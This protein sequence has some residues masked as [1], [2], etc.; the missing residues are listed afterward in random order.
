MGYPA[1]MFLAFGRH[2]ERQANISKALWCY[3]KGLLKAPSPRIA[4]YLQYRSAL[5]Y[6]K[7]GNQDLA[8]KGFRRVVTRYTGNTTLVAKANRFLDSLDRATADLKRVAL[9]GVETYTEYKSAYCVPSS[10]A[11]AMKYWGSDVDAHT[12]GA[13]ITGLGTGTYAV[14]QRWYA[15]QQQFNFQLHYFENPADTISAAHLKKAAGEHA[16]FFFPVT[17]LYR[18]FPSLR[19]SLDKR[20]NPDQ[21]SEAIIDYFSDDFD[22]GTHLAG[23]YHDERWAMP[24]W[25]L[26]FSIEYLIG[27]KQFAKASGLL[28]SIDDH[29]QLSKKMQYYSG[30]LALANG[31]YEIGIDR[32]SK[33]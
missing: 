10:L 7:L 18:E 27:Q 16:D 11:L 32:L 13:H 33:G 3:E 29:G 2:H 1:D 23:Q 15:E 5:I 4:S 22:E 24:D 20:Y 25:A 31:E 9:D 19:T 26:R 12:I 21:I 8:Q 14:D 17:I 28:S 6:H 30:I